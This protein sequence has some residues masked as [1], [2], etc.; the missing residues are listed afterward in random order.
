MLLSF[1]VVV[2]HERHSHVTSHFI[3]EGDEKNAPLR[4]VKALRRRGISLNV[5]E[6]EVL[7]LKVTMTLKVDR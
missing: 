2:G 4:V 1:M 7:S 6:N 3:G 5:R